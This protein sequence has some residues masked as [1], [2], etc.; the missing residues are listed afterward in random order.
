MQLFLVTLHC[1]IGA[2]ESPHDCLVI[3]Q[4]SE[5]LIVD[6]E[7]GYNGSLTQMFH[8][9]VYD[10]VMEH[11][12][13]NLTKLDRPNFQ[14]TNLLPGTSYVLVIYAS[15]IKGR[16]NSVALVGTTLHPAE[17]RTGKIN[18]LYSIKFLKFI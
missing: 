13:G 18:I 11:M 15:N 16:S 2:P 4:T 8:L 3:N 10:S 9:E 12:T 5:V 17:K 7:P 6:C 14:A 1:Y